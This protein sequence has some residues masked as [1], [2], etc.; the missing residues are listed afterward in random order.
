MQGDG[1]NDSLKG[2]TSIV[3]KRFDFIRMDLLAT[4][5]QP[6][7]V[8]FEDI[9]KKQFFL[10][11]DDIE[12]IFEIGTKAFIHPSNRRHPSP[13][14]KMDTT[15]FKSEEIRREVL[16]AKQAVKDII[17]WS[18]YSVYAFLVLINSFSFLITHKKHLIAGREGSCSELV[19]RALPPPPPPL[20]ISLESDRSPEGLS[21][22][23][24]ELNELERDFMFFKLGVPAYLNF[25]FLV[26]RTGQL[27]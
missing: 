27:K 11:L 10:P 17:P 4:T 19:Y 25:G 12:A 20:D 21:V 3:S 22:I 16:S 24:D 23:C 2:E 9:L 6:S 8:E 14:G 18:L 7:P 26:I 13:S 5:I 15:H 1:I